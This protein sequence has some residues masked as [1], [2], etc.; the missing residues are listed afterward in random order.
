MVTQ[1]NQW[2]NCPKVKVLEGKFSNEA[3]PL[4]QEKFYNLKK[5][6]IVDS[7]TCRQI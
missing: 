3:N 4:Q 5:S 1:R 2:N 7:T 6:I